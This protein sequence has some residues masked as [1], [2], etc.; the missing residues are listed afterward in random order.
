MKRLPEDKMGKTVKIIVDKMG[1]DKMGINHTVMFEGKF[2]QNEAQ[3]L[4]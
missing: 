2:S 3:I 1:I 4:F